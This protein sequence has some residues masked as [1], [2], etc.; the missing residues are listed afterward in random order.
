MEED[1]D[2]SI[3]DINDLISRIKLQREMRN[4][5]KYLAKILSEELAAAIDKEIIDKLRG[6]SNSSEDGLE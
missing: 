4:P 3:I 5:E 6:M 2:Y 1:E